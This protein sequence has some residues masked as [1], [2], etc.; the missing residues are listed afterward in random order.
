MSRRMRNFSWFTL[1]LASSSSC[2]SASSWSMARFIFSRSK[3]M[4]SSIQLRICT[5][6]MAP[7]LSC[8]LFSSS[9]FSRTFFWRTMPSISRFMAW[10][11]VSAL[12]SFFSSRI[13]CCSLALRSMLRTLFASFTTLFSASIWTSCLLMSSLA[14]SKLVVISLPTAIL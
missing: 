12:D 13:T 4:R 14:R 2:F 6:S 3:A 11:A 5:F 7:L 9:A 8:S 10:T 1:I